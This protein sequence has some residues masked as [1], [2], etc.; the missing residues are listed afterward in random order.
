MDATTQRATLRPL[1]IAL[2]FI[3]G[4][5]D[6]V[7]DQP[8]T[9]QQTLQAIGRRLSQSW[10]ERDLTT[11]ASRGELLL[12]VLSSRERAALARGYL[13]FKIDVPVVVDVA[14]AAGSI[15][16][17]IDELGFRRTEVVLENPDTKWMLFRRT[18]RPGWVGLGVNGLDKTPLAHY[19]TFVRPLDSRDRAAHRL[20][21][22]LD[23]RLAATW[24]AT[25][26]RPGASAARDSRRPFRSIPADL[27]GAVMF[28]ASH[29]ARHSALLAAGRVWKTHVA[30]ST[31]PDQVTI[32]FGTDA[33]R[34]LVWT[35]RTSTD[36]KLTALR[37]ARP[38]RTDN[39]APATGG[40]GATGDDV[41]IVT[42]ESTCVAVPD[43]LN[44]PVVR[45][46]RVSVDRLEPD[47]V[48]RYSL[49]DGTPQGWAPWQSVKTG[50]D[51]SH[52]TRFLYLGDAQ[53]GLE[54]WGR[55]LRTA[56]SRDPAIDFIVIAGDL[57]DRGNER[58]NW[59][60]FFLR[61]RGVFDHWPLMP[62]SGN[63]E[64]LD[65]GPRLFRSIFEL[66][67][68]GPHGMDSGLVYHFECGDAFFAVL[69][70]TLAACDANVARRQA[71]WLDVTLRESKAC[72]KFVI[73][74]HPLYPSHPWRDTLALRQHWVP[75]FDKHRVDFVLQGHD[76]AYQ[77]TYPLRSHRRVGDRGNGTIYLIAVS[78]DKFVEC[79]RRP[80]VEVSRSGVSTYQTFDIDSRSNRLTYRAC[81]EDG[82]VI[83][84]LCIEKA[85]ANRER[86]R[87][88]RPQTDASGLTSRSHESRPS[89]AALLPR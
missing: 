75:I 24:K 74:H 32:A 71:H 47:T 8:P 77:R 41:R 12:R 78:G 40:V 65:R 25:T 39:H 48:Y 69:D 5:T 82:T 14:T 19:V 61:A 88:Q 80:Y 43:L 21:V 35:W 7:H 36:I 31:R 53:T 76:H 64:Y 30:S 9:T 79:T 1:L 6:A 81:A 20:S 4:G 50:P 45:R 68:N 51:H 72:W 29:S 60:H 28:H 17:W 46:H 11:I 63:H 67:H 73:F 52:G 13:R 18:F 3:A 84:E 16:F 70:S 38:R 26:A 37:I 62:C 33:A 27:I 58:T 23:E 85:L 2:S 66:P 22:G 86:E 89:T 55:L 49:G 57:V 87:Y 59:D 42:G 15:P 34:E 44:D 10:S 54:R 83:D 56:T